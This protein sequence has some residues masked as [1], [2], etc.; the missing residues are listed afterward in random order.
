MIRFNCPTCERPYELPDAMA[1]L[2]LVCKQCGQRLTPPAPTPDPPPPPPK[3]IP[4][5]LPKPIA[6]P[7]PAPLPPKPVFAAPRPDEPPD[8]DDVLVTK[9]DSTPDIDFNVGGPTAASLSDAARARPTGLS[10]TNRPRPADL[11]ATEPEINL[12]LLPPA[13]P[14]PPK[15]A[16]PPA[17]APPPGAKPEPTLL[18]FVADLVVFVLLVVVGMIFGEFLARKPTGEVLSEAGSATKFPPVDLLLWAAPP[19]LFGLVY[20]LLGSRERSVGAWLRRR[21]A[22]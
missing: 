20:L 22:R 10:D 21:Q 6:K 13:P 7:A 4:L 5:A 8:D 16:R 9:A 3:P 18:P 19:V 2:P 14:A 12:D 17:P 15:P 11:E 1:H